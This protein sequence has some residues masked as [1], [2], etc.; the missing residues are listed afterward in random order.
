[1][2][3]LENLIKNYGTLT[4]SF[5]D[6]PSHSIKSLL[7]G[8]ECYSH[9]QAHTGEIAMR[10]EFS[11]PVK[12]KSFMMQGMKQYYDNGPKHIKFFVN[13]EFLNLSFGVLSIATPTAALT[14]SRDQ[15]TPAW[16][17]I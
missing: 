10:F 11:K 16:G 15:I 5:G 6:D 3:D 13:A 7:S 1:M 4:H 12:V 17:T 14:L 8:G 9:R 2:S